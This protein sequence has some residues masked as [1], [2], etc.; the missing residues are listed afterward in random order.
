MSYIY[1]KFRPET[2]TRKPFDCGDADLNGFLVETTAETPN[3][4]QHEKEMLAVTYVVEDNENHEILAYFSI[5]HDKIEREF[6]DHGIWNQLSR[7]I[8]NAKRR[9]SYPALKIG[10]LAVSRNA[11]KTGL[12]R[13]IISFIKAWFY[14]ESKAGCRYITVDAYRQAEEFYSKCRFKRL[15]KTSPEEETVLMY[16]DLKTIVR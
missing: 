5:L 14:N 3:A 13:E 11:Q 4:Q 15:L 10:R 8:P 12:G 7:K 9:S 2:D 6:S 1:R 16:Y